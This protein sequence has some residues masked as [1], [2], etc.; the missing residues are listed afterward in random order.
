[1]FFTLDLRDAAGRGPHPFCAPRAPVPHLWRDEN[2]A[3]FHTVRKSEE[4]LE[5]AQANAG[6]DDLHLLAPAESDSGASRCP[7]GCPAPTAVLPL[8]SVVVIK[9]ILSF[10]KRIF[11]ALKEEGGGVMRGRSSGKTA[12]PVPGLTRVGGGVYKEDSIREGLCK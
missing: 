5:T 11:I 4:E 1:M 2:P 9:G 7:S 3:R 8:F 10:N 6:P 12:P